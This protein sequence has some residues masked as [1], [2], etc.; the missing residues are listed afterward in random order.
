MDIQGF[1]PEAL[2]GLRETLRRDRPLVSIE[3]SPENTA[4]FGSFERFKEYLP[5]G[6]SFLRTRPWNLGPMRGTVT[7]S[8]SGEAFPALSCIPKP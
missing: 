6:Y 4:K 3:I 7:E 2:S 8:Y 1:E 5:E